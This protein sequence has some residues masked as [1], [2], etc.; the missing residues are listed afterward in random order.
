V[1]IV[2]PEIEECILQGG[3][4]AGEGALIAKLQENYDATTPV[5]VVAKKNWFGRCVY[6]A[7][8]DVC[9][10]EAVTMTWN[11]DPIAASGENANQALAGRG[12]KIATFHMVAFTQ[13]ICDRYSHIYGTEGE[14]YADSSTIVLQD[15]NSGEKK[16]FY[17]HLA[18][19]GHGG[20]DDGLARQFVLAVDRVKNHGEEVAQAQKEYIGCTLEEVIRSH[21]MVF[22]A[23]EARRKKVV[24]DFPAWWE[25]EV[26]RRLVE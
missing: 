2:V 18:G 7:D 13:K 11:D 3:R 12:A 16:T 8:N 22:A 6:E 10:D 4:D 24:L 26:E 25:R 23:E 20:G 19:K 14:I 17:P 9:D 21:A 15:F 5:E 1:D